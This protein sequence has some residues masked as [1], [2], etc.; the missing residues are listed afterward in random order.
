[1]SEEDSARKALLLATAAVTERELVRVL[2]WMG[3][4][5]PAVM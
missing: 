5:A 4:S 2:G 3:V 1:L